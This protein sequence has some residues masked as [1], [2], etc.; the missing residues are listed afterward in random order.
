MTVPC[1]KGFHWHFPIF[2]IETQT[3]WSDYYLCEVNEHRDPIFL[4]ILQ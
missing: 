1:I 4:Y 2:P 3:R